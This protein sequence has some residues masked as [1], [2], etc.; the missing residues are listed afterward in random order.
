MRLTKALVRK[1]KDVNVSPAPN[2]FTDKI[3]R[4]VQINTTFIRNRETYGEKNIFIFKS[5]ALCISRLHSH[6]L[7]S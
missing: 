1:H 4:V 2:G 7:S 3:Q 6:A 5:M